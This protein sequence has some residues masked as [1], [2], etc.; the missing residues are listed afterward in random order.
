MQCN[1]DEVMGMKVTIWEFINRLG[2]LLY[3]AQVEILKD[4]YPSMKED[5]APIVKYIKQ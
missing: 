3:P 1:R 2:I 4:I 5:P